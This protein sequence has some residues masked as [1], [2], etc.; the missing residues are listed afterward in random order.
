M[1]RLLECRICNLNS[2]ETRIKLKSD[3]NLPKIFFHLHQWKP[4]KNDEKCFLFHVKSFFVLKVFR[5]R[6]KI[7]FDTLS[8]ILAAKVSH[9][10]PSTLPGLT[11]WPSTI[12]S[13][14]VQTKLLANVTFNILAISLTIDQ[15]KSETQI[16]LF[17]Y[18]RQIEDSRTRKMEFYTSNS[19]HT[20]KLRQ[21]V[22]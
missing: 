18:Q 17:N 8:D 5:G 4:F 21:V 6:G 1:K 3:S 11:Q 13:K 12:A 14:H 2:E 7:I 9:P 19:N 10:S 22:C 15:H 16:K 20:A